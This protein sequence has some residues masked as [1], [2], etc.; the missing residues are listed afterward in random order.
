M[1]ITGAEAAAFIRVNLG[2]PA[3]ELLETLTKWTTVIVLK[4]LTNTPILSSQASQSTWPA[5][6]T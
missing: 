2:E 5:T 1:S 4:F 6:V 3:P